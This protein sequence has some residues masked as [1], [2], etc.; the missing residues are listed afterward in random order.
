MEALLAL[1]FIADQL[2]LM[3][4]WSHKIKAVRQ[5]QPL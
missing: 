2:V 4:N 3:A 1:E 5:I